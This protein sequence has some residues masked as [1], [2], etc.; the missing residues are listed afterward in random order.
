MGHQHRID[1]VAGH[2]TAR[3]PQTH[4]V[5]PGLGR[6]GEAGHDHHGRQPDCPQLASAAEVAEFTVLT[7]NQRICYQ[8]QLLIQQQSISAHCSCSRRHQTPRKRSLGQLKPHLLRDT[9]L[10]LHNKSA[11]GALLCLTQKGAGGADEVGQ[12]QQMLLALGMGQHLG[13]LVLELHPA[14][15]VLI[16]GKQDRPVAR[17]LVH[18]IHR[19]I[20]AAAGSGLCATWPRL[21]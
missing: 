1:P 16:W 17:Q 10:A 8:L 21:N 9:R 4:H 5:A 19:P 20:L 15:Q 14:A 2:R 7:Q 12:I 11:S 3:R 6:A 18:Q 13:L